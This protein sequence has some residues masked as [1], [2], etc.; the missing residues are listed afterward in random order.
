MSTKALSRNDLQSLP[1]VLPTDARQAELIDLVARFAPT[2]GTHG[3][4]IAPLL[5]ARASEPAQ[6]LFTVY[7]PC[8]GVVVQGSKQATLGREVFRYDPLNY[9]VVSVTLP[10]MGQILEATP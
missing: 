4:A 7:E 10:A 6:K 2:D 9:L 5:L 3:T 1:E 8:L